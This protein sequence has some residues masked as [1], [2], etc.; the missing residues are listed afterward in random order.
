MCQSCTAWQ[1]HASAKLNKAG[2][3]AHSHPWPTRPTAHAPGAII[4][5]ARSPPPPP[6]CTGRSKTSV[7]RAGDLSHAW[8]C[9][10]LPRPAPLPAPD[11]LTRGKNK[12]LATP[13]PPAAGS[14]TH[15]SQRDHQ[16]PARGDGYSRRLLAD[17]GAPAV[18]PATQGVGAVGERAAQGADQLVEVLASLD[19]AGPGEFG[20]LVVAGVEPGGAPGGGG[21]GAGRG[22]RGGGEGRVRRGRVA[23]GGE[24]GATLKAGIIGQGRA[25]VAH[26]V[27]AHYYN[28]VATM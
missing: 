21:G 24:G 1:R 28:F 25:G 18:G 9:D 22:G 26:T 7:R 23:G 11:G 19:A 20:V 2:V 27:A 16:P 10:A 13:H 3:T 5:R 4:M 14:G 17:P 8:G 15:P 12:R 6:A